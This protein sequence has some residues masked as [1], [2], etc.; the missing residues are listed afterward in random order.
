VHNLDK[1]ARHSLQGYAS[2]SLASYCPGSVTHELQAWRPALSL[3]Q[4]IQEFY[5]G[6]APELQDLG[7]VT[8]PAASPYDDGQK[9]APLVKIGTPAEVTGWLRVSTHVAVHYSDL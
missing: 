3:E 8:Y 9:K 5:I 2:I 4:R 6:G 7:F 1:E